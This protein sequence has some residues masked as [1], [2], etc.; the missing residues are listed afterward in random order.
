M[1]SKGFGWDEGDHDVP[2]SG[3]MD[4]L[5]AWLEKNHHLWQLGLQLAATARYYREVY[6]HVPFNESGWYSPN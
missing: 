6:Q 2:I 1:H 5:E 4:A 3:S